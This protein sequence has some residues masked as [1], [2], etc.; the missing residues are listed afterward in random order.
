MRRIFTAAAALALGG[1]VCFLRPTVA[2]AGDRAAPR[3]EEAEPGRPSPKQAKWVVHSVELSTK[4]KNPFDGRVV[5]KS[6]GGNSQSYLS[7]YWGGQCK[8]TRLLRSRLDL[9]LLAMQK[10]YGVAIPAFPIRYENAVVMCMQS[11]R[12][13]V[14]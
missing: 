8:G 5:L 2:Q 13:T 12:V 9:L 6:Q 1:A 10:G 11:V 4:K 7:Y 3:G 14:E